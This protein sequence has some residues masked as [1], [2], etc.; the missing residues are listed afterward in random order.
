MKAITH[1]NPKS[2]YVRRFLASLT[3]VGLGSSALMAQDDA[4]EASEEVFELSPFVVDGSEDSGYVTNQSLSG[5]RFSQNL[6]DIPANIS[7]ITAEM[8]ED[9]GAYDVQD[10]M[11]WSVNSEVSGVGETTSSDATGITD[12]ERRNLT[13]NIRGIQSTT[14]RNFFKWSINSDGYNVGRIDTSRGPNAL[15]FGASSL[16][17]LNNITTKQAIFK[18]VNKVS[19]S[20][21]STGGGRAALDVNKVLID[22]KL[23]LRFNTFYHDMDSWRDY[24]NS[25]KDGFALA[26]TWKVNDTFT[27]RFEGEKGT[28]E[29]VAPKS[30]IRDNTNGWDHSTLEVAVANPNTAA[31]RRAAN[32]ANAA[33][34]VA[35]IAANYAPIIDINNLDAGAVSWAGQVISRG[36]GAFLKPFVDVGLTSGTEYVPMDLTE[37]TTLVDDPADSF[38]SALLLPDWDYGNLLMAGSVVGEHETYSV[39]LEKK[40]SDNFFVEVA[41]NH[42]DENR[43]WH[44]QDGGPNQI[45]Y[46]LSPT[47]PDGYTIDGS[48]DNPNFLKPYITAMPGVREDYVQSDEFRA[49]GIYRMKWEWLELDVGGNVSY[50]SSQSGQYRRALTIVDGDNPDLSASENKPRFRHYLSDPTDGFTQYRDGETYTIGGS[51]LE[52]VNAGTG[53]GQAHTQDQLTSMM[54][55]TSGSWGH[56]GKL[57]TTIGIRRD[58]FDVEAFNNYITDPVTKEYLRSELSDTDA[59]TIDSPSYGAVYHLTDWLSVYGNY[60]KSFVFGNKRQLSFL[61]ETVAPPIGE[62]TEYGVRFRFGR[63]LSG[64]LNT[65]DSQQENNPINVNNIVNQIGFIHDALGWDELGQRSDTATTAS[66]GYEFRL[67]GNPTKSWTLTGSVSFPERMNTDSYGFAMDEYLSTVP[68]TW[69]EAAGVDAA[70]A[71]GITSP[72]DIA[73]IDTSEGSGVDVEAIDAITTRWTNILNIIE[74][75]RVNDGLGATRLSKINGNFLTRYSFREGSLKGLSLGAGVRYNGERVLNRTAEGDEIVSDDYLTYKVFAKYGFKWKDLKWNVSLNI[76]NPFNDLN[77]E[78]KTVNATTLDGITY[79]ISSPRSAKLGVGVDF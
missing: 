5:S 21:S 70:T 8:M 47:L 77:F 20:F 30:A 59:D 22:D 68:A 73:N 74:N 27:V 37:Q 32:A 12:L 1:D 7:V 26:G 57:K 69:L 11:A 45:Y 39:Y 34:G 14:A 53:G 43:K 60:S 50:R 63:K 49:L 35:A 23:A 65:Y 4:N 3:C 31:N 46:D 61:G 62:S 40:F 56:E 55:F 66:E 18:E 16:A 38:Q 42:Q 2:R 9:L 48:S 64:S 44:S 52:Y 28:T 6:N 25:K 10:A 78:Y 75:R 67:T 79:N 24:G 36:D 51:T 54:L 33:A 13:I 17:G 15:L 41:Y 76:D 58:K 19:T 29:N 72:D 71:A